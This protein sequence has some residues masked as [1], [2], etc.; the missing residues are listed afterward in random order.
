M[1]DSAPSS[2]SR[3]YSIPGTLD[4][5]SISETQCRIPAGGLC[6]AC[7]E[8]NQVDKKIKEAAALLQQLIRQ[9]E[10]LKTERNCHHDQLI[11][12]LPTELVSR[13][14]ALCAS[15][16]PVS[17]DSMKVPPLYRQRKPLVSAPWELGVV[18]RSWR[19]VV[20]ST[21]QLW[22]VISV[23]M[24]RRREAG[25]SEFVQ[26]WLL[27]SGDLP[28]T[29]S[30]YT[31]A[32]SDTVPFEV[33]STSEEPKAMQL[34]AAINQ[35]SQRWRYLDVSLPV[36]FS[37]HLRGVSSG[38]SKLQSI[39][40]GRPLGPRNTRSITFQMHVTPSPS[41]VALEYIGF[42]AFDINW[43]NVTHATIQSFSVAECLEMLRS[44]HQLT[45]FAVSY[46][47]NDQDPHESPSEN[48]KI[49]HNHLQVCEVSSIS[50]LDLLFSH[51]VLP[52]L[53]NLHL[54]D[55]LSAA[56]SLVSRSDCKITELS[57]NQSET[58]LS[59]EEDLITLLKLCPSLTHLTLLECPISD[60][61]FQELGHDKT[62]DQQQSTLSQFLPVLSSLSIE[63]LLRFRWDSLT[64]MFNRH[65]DPLYAP[66][67]KL[68]YLKVTILE[69]ERSESDEL[70]D[71]S[72]DGVTEPLSRLIPKNVASSLLSLLDSEEVVII[73]EDEYKHSLLHTA[74]ASEG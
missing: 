4:I 21:P 40:L 56:A 59:S 17:V 6:T 69:G 25:Y 66:R 68:R 16:P 61:F 20:Y 27:R 71:E 19:D 24:S 64:N 18:S 26:E 1:Q 67:R 70:S 15:Y 9:R 10:E 62:P 47:Y 32:R 43:D 23:N 11:Q 14:F 49:V 28:L 42:K 48:L 55:N 58:R 74:L 54:F 52:S 63:A 38:T 35:T 51:L 37:G 50:R 65:P 46:V 72:D 45:H 36:P 13:I 8:L 29:L 60:I 39:H 5:I 22:T 30:L 41:R 3:L 57:V 53:I 34:L 31:S 73:I 7:I 12:R 44:A 2:S 33:L